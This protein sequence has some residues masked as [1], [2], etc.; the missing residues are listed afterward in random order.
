MKALVTKVIDG[1]TFDVLLEGLVPDRVRIA[2]FN[3]PEMG[4]LSGL[5]TQ[6]TLE[7]KI[8]RH[9]VK[10]VPKARDNHGRMVADVYLLN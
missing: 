3:A 8:L 10:L 6:G 9:W 4:T 5:P 7:A 1:D 2:G